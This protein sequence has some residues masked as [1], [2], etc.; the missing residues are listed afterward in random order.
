MRIL[1]VEDDPAIAAGLCAGLRDSGHAVDLLHDGRQA[2]TA[3][4]GRTHELL[5]LDLGLPSMAG[6]HVLRKLRNRNE[7]LAVL[8]IT[9]RG[10]RR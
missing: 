2:W 3:L 10:Q 4:E 5:V 7:D 8:V 6:D 9:A 1:V